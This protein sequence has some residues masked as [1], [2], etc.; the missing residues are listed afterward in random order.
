MWMTILIIGLILF[1][2]FLIA[3]G[4]L[5]SKNIGYQ[6]EI[7]DN[8]K[9]LLDSLHYDDK[10]SEGDNLREYEERFNYIKKISDPQDHTEE[11][12]YYKQHRDL[13]V[14]CSDEY[15][16]LNELIN[17]LEKRTEKFN[18][19]NEINKE[20]ANVYESYGYKD[21]NVFTDRF[22]EKEEKI[23]ALI[24][25]K[26]PTNSLTNGKFIDSLEYWSSTFHKITAQLVSIFLLW[27]SSGQEELIQTNLESLEEVIDKLSRIEA[28]LIISLNKS[29]NDDQRI[30]DL[31]KDMSEIIKSIK[32]YK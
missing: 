23:R 24:N 16:S 1:V 10:F 14:G 20:N 9:I 5:Y 28:E 3:K 26:F 4:I 31:I 27:D 11:I 32:E 25:Q 22:T 13:L 30:E 7:D 8:P 15:F 21:L 19:Y 2:I 29:E 18:A 6:K 17:L 12:E